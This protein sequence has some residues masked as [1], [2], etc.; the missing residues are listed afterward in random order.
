[1]IGAA[2][3]NLMTS[4]SPLHLNQIFVSI[5]NPFFFLFVNFF[6]SQ[7]LIVC[8]NYIFCI[9]CQEKIKKVPEILVTYSSFD[10]NAVLCYLTTHLLP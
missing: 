7:W 4:C 3:S 2:S 9:K 6:I 8:L 1:M 5:V 10:P